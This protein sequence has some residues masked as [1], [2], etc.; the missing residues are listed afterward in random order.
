MKNRQKTSDTQKPRS[1]IS[2][3]MAR[4]K[5]TFIDVLPNKEERPSR[6]HSAKVNRTPDIYRR[7]LVM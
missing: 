6:N 1:E 4:I 2:E 7:K 5:P 3:N